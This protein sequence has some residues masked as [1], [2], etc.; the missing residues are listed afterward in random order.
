VAPGSG[1]ASTIIVATTIASPS[2]LPARHLPGAPGALTGG[3]GTSG[4]RI[5]HRIRLPHCGHHHHHRRHLP[6]IHWDLSAAPMS[7]RHHRQRV[8]RGRVVTVAIVS[9][10]GCGCGCPQSPPCHGATVPELRPRAA[11]GPCCP[12]MPPFCARRS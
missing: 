3:G 12:Q 1:T 8:L 10:R 2:S 5:W 9:S 6:D 7:S 4:T 11:S